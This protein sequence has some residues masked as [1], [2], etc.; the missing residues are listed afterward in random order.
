MRDQTVNSTEMDSNYEKIDKISTGSEAFVEQ[1]WYESDLQLAAELGKTLLER[2]KELEGNLKQ[3]QQVIE[4]K[5]LEIEHLTKQT[6]SLREVNESRI[7]VYEQ[8]EISLQDL[9]KTNQRLQHES[10]VDKKKIRSTCSMV[11]TLEKKCDE[12]Q[13]TVD[14]LRAA[15]RQH[16]HK[17]RERRRTLGLGAEFDSA[18]LRR[19]LSVENGLSRRS[20]EQHS[21][22]AEK[23]ADY[24]RLQQT[25]RELRTQKS[26]EQRL[27][28]DLELDVAG[29]VQMNEQLRDQVAVLQQ[30]EVVI[31]A[32][33]MELQEMEEEY[34]SDLCCRHRW[35]HDTPDAGHQKQPSTIL[36]SEHEVE[37]EATVETFERC[38][39]VRLHNGGQ[40]YGSQEVL[41]SAGKVIALTNDDDR[42]MDGEPSSLESSLLS[43]LDTQYRLLIEKY[44]AMVDARRL[45][46]LSE[47]SRATAACASGS[48][49]EPDDEECHS[50]PWISTAEES[51]ST[52]SGFSDADVG[53]AHK[54][55][56]TDVRHPMRP[57][58]VDGN[59]TAGLRARRNPLENHFNQTPEYKKLFQEIFLVLKKSIGYDGEGATGTPPF[60]ATQD[61]FPAL[62]AAA[63]SSSRPELAGRQPTPDR[64]YADVVNSSCR[65]SRFRRQK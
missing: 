14:E 38:A 39:L 19:V 33:Q 20:D 63:P 13:K 5:T 27:R 50:L 47:Q 60:T 22:D 18:E 32:L 1:E 46:E 21:W 16:L 6:T 4:D 62:C 24:L 64:S 59:L 7:K 26:R 34:S 25:A 44:K 23:E 42:E 57:T 3:Q 65:P 30:R 15:S 52:S 35:N 61:A 11:E 58:R 31:K 37:D 45:V 51:S 17:R 54:S 48:S 10:T 55:V 8:L 49:N 36:D 40:A 56:Q 29:L 43:E 53:Q 28:E 41:G 9:E 12:L 2:N